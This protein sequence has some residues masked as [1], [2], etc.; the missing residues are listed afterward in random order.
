MPETFDVDRAF[1]ALAHDVMDRTAPPSAFA[2]IKQARRRRRTA[3]ATVALAVA[4]VVTGVGVPA[5][6]GGDSTGDVATEG[7][8]ALP[9]PARFTPEGWGT[10]GDAAP[11]TPMVSS[12]L[13]SFIAPSPT[14]LRPAATGQSVLGRG[15]ARLIAMFYD[16]ADDAGSADQAVSLATDASNA[17]S[18]ATPSI[19]Y[20]GGTVQHLVD[21][22]KGVT[23]DLWVA[24]LG[25]RVGFVAAVG[26]RAAEADEVVA[27]A[28]ALMGALQYPG[29]WEPA[30]PSSSES[31]A[32]FAAEVNDA[33][34]DGLFG[35]WFPAWRQGPVD[36][37]LPC[38][39]LT[40]DS[41]AS[42]SGSM[43]GGGVSINSYT[44]PTPAEAAT[45][46]RGAGVGA[47]AVQLDAVDDRHGRQVRMG[48]HL[49]RRQPLD[50]RG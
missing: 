33:T 14:P 49:G 12:C 4:V 7:L 6:T 24:R 46:R 5:L 2:A 44:W 50:R 35:G 42:G 17:C 20:I 41:P 36:G 16:F 25:N 45:A 48:R 34:I 28:D 30:A 3:L 1:E 13:S 37:G 38:A 15:D 26:E 32:A 21:V 23:T 9:S 40:W 18:S 27:I 31:E 39:A 22:E 11:D 10:V 43:P 47:R 8:R 29:T 19:R